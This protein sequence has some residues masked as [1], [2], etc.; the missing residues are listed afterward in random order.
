MKWRDA[1]PEP[2]P[3]STARPPKAERLRTGH[4]F[5]Y[6]GCRPNSSGAALLADPIIVARAVA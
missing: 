2:M 5:R 6:V 1:A 3:A 4:Y